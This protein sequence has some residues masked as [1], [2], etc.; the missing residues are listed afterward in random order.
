[1]CNGCCCGNTSKGHSEVPIQYLEEIWEINDISKQ[2]E[3]D[4]SECLGPCSWHNVAVLEAEGQQIWVGDLSQPSHYEA[5]ADWA[6]K[7]AYQTMVE[8]PS[9]LKSNIFDPDGQD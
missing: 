8:I 1:V 5:I 9:I 6:K 2:V 4:I 3:L 7:S